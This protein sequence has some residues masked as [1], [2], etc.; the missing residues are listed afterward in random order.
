[1]ID[2]MIVTSTLLQFRQKPSRTHKPVNST[3]AGSA[4]LRFRCTYAALAMAR[5]G[6]PMQRI[7]V[8]VMS[9]CERKLTSQLR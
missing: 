4:D 3:H 6:A 8:V 5:H 1:M 2:R 9:V 7:S